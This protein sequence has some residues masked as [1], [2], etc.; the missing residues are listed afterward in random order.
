MRCEFYIASDRI[1]YLDKYRV[2]YTVVSNLNGFPRIVLDTTGTNMQC[3]MEAI[4][5]YSQ[6][7]EANAITNLFKQT[8]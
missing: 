8:A 3:F 2:N 5:I 7:R 1:P 6:E 4:E